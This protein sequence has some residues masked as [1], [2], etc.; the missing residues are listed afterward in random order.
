MKRFGASADVDS[1]PAVKTRNT[2]R[3]P[4]PV[5]APPGAVGTEKILDELSDELFA[6][7]RRTDQRRRGAAYL[8]GLLAT[9]GRKSIRNMAALIGGTG[10]GQ[11]L[12]HFICSS[13]WD[14][15]PVR[16]AL[17]E[18]LVRTAPPRAW[19]VR[20]LLIPKTGRHSVGVGRYGGK[21]Y[22][23]SAQMAMGVWAASEN[24]AVPVHWNLHLP[25]SEDA[26]APVADGVD[27]GLEVLTEWGLPPRPVVLDLEGDAAAPAMRRLRAA[28]LH[29]VAR[30]T[31]DVPLQVVE[32]ALV[33]HRGRVM[34]AEEVLRAAQ[35]LRRPVRGTGGGPHTRPRAPRRP[36][37][38][39]PDMAAAVR[40]G[41]A[42]RSRAGAG[43][44]L[45]GIGPADR[46]WPREMWL[47]ALPYP[48]STV[49]VPAYGGLL[50]LTD[51]AQDTVGERVGLRDYA[52]RS[53]A[54]W[55]RHATLA[56]AA[57]AVAMLSP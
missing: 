21:E 23:M 31:G 43:L 40:V 30:I 38:G 46:Y 42:D 8:R 4:G 13:T 45:V 10:T 5:P 49:A 17:A 32:P 2:P 15:V 25:A 18:Y 41:L 54:G 7:L 36:H 50:R 22:P 47:S 24:V 11:S 48:Q 26:P 29:P 14:W 12:H 51:H 3:L 16:R 35:D 20:P 27:A 19:V 1:A 53:Y 37:A 34:R 52:G 55:H 28:G 39:R 33:G 9:P 57:H 44:V 56:S 6:S